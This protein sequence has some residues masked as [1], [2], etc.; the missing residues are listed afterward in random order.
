[1]LTHVARFATYFALLLGLIDCA[2]NGETAGA[3][4]GFSFLGF[5]FSRLLLC[6]RF[7]MTLPS[8]CA[9]LVIIDLRAARGKRTL[10]LHIN[11]AQLHRPAPA[12]SQ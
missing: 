1:M 5:R 3:S 7:A 4:L 2:A 12:N 11:K 10:P 6:S 8:I 9:D